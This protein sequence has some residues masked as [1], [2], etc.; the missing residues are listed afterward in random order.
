MSRLDVPTFADPA[1]QG[2]LHQAV[3]TGQAHGSKAYG[4][5]A[6]IIRVFATVIQLLSQ[7]S[8]LFNLL[9]GQPDGYL[10][11]FLSFAHGLVQWMKTNKPF[12]SASGSCSTLASPF[13]PTPSLIISVVWAA[14]TNNPDFLRSEGLK[15]T[16]SDPIHRQEIVAAGIGPFLLSRMNDL[17]SVPT[18]SETPYTEYRESI[19]RISDHASHFYE[20]Y[21][22]HKQRGIPLDLFFEEIVRALPE[23]CFL[24]TL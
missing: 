16:V 23:A 11:A 1:I 2:Q 7:L 8:V 21:S 12:V 10:L 24:Y 3:P 18:S 19:A 4:A 6:T 22:R 15:Q 5:V 9:K 20:A 17:F 13:G 14:T